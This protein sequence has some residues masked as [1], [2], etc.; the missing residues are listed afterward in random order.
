MKKSYLIFVVLLLFCIIICVSGYCSDFISIDKKINDDSYGRS[1]VSRSVASTQASLDAAE[2]VVT[3]KNEINIAAQN[4]LNPVPAPT[5]NLEPIHITGNV[6]L[7]EPLVIPEG[8]VLIIDGSLTFNSNLYPQGLDN[9]NIQNIPAGAISGWVTTS[10]STCNIS[11]T[12]NL[13]VTGDT[14]INGSVVVSGNLT[15]AVSGTLTINGTLAVNGTLDINTTTTNITGGNWGQN[16]GST[17]SVIGTQIPII[18][19]TGSHGGILNPG[20]VTTSTVTTS[21]IS[22]K[23]N[24]EWQKEMQAKVIRD[25]FEKERQGLKDILSGQ[26]EREK[27]EEAIDLLGK[28]KKEQNN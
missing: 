6:V 10:N 24:N 23:I 19:G 15:I 5:A 4:I 11:E 14:V 12:G 13:S 9:H 18:S 22:S 16:T 1:V 21:D 26:G 3:N 25:R 17:I 7:N 20:S 27:V 2:F 28:E 8:Q